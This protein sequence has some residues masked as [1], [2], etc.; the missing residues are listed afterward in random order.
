MNPEQ[1]YDELLKRMK[2][3]AVLGNTAGVLGWDQ[4]VYMP[5]AN[6]PYRA[7]QLSLLAGMLHHKFT[8]PAVG[9]WISQAES[10]KTLTGDPLSDSAVNLREWRRSYDRSKKL[11][12]KL[13]EEMARVTSQAQVEWVEA[14][15]ENKFSRFQPWLEKIVVLTQEQA[16]CY[17]YQDHPYDALLEDYEPGLTTAQLNQLFPPLKKSLAEMVAKITSAKRQPD[18]AILKRKCP[19][20]LQQAFCRKLAE[21]IGFDFNKGRIDVS[22]HPFTTGLGPADTR[23]TTRFEETNFEN[24]FFSTLH[25]S[26][27]GIYDQNLPSDEHYGTPRASA[28][29]LGIHESQSRLWEN[30]VG[31]SRPFWDYFYPELKKS[32]PGVFDDVS[33]D[34]FHFAINHSAPSFIRT[35]SDEVTYNLHIC[36]R[37]DIE[38]AVIAGNLKPADIPGV[39]NESMKKYFG[40][41]PP[42]DAVGCLQDVHWSHGSFGYFPTYTL[43][44]LYSAQFFAAADKEVGPLGEKFGKGDFKPLKKW[45]NEKIHAHGQRYRANE[46]CKKATGEELS[47]AYFLKY[48]EKK[49]GALYGF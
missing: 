22:A 42:T 2:E 43:G 46:L 44:N 24:A 32:F 10:S 5:A 39:W 3:I 8:D 12:Q 49:F 18:L 4:E 47:S 15:R 34:A 1:A 30:L 6:A 17:G 26:G 37:Y 25:E 33:L 23:I 7:E 14:R 36:L 45:L 27:H 28:V 20:P 40:L 41:T 9:G 29:S 13:V 11:P 48:L 35:E 31:R 21:A 19:I 38:V 16:K